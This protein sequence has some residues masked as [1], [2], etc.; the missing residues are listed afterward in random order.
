MLGQG[1]EPVLFEQGDIGTQI[2]RHCPWLPKENVRYAYS[3]I[4]GA[5]GPAA[6]QQVTKFTNSIQEIRRQ[7][8]VENEPMGVDMIDLNMISSFNAAGIN[9]VDG[10]TPMVEARTIKNEDELE[11]M[12]IV[13]AICD[14][15][16][17]AIANYMRAGMQEHEITAITLDYLYRIPGIT[18]GE[19]GIVSSGPQSWRN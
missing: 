6:E 2:N 16:H 17:T 15:A 9:W 4:K 14:G 8:G 10:M 13:A 12:R 1:A 18:D 5:V 11:A 3:W 7:Y 19:D